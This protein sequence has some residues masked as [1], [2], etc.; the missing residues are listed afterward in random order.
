MLRHFFANRNLRRLSSRWRE[1]KEND[2]DNDDDD[3]TDDEEEEE[4]EKNGI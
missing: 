1:D 3:H 4:M 2:N